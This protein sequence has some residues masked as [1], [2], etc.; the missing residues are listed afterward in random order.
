LSEF[1]PDYY[2]DEYYRKRNYSDLDPY[3]KFLLLD[4]LNIGLNKRIR[5]LDIG[6]GTGIYLNFLKEMGFVAYGIDF[7]IPALKISKQIQASATKIPFKNDTFDFILSAHLIEHLES[8]KMQEMLNESQRVLKPGGK[9]FL[10]T[11]NGWCLG[12]FVL[13]KDWFKDPSHINIYNPKKIKNVLKKNQ[14][15]DIKL[16]HRIPFNLQKEEQ[17]KFIISY[18]GLD[19]L[20]NKFPILQDLMFFFITSTLL[21][22]FR[23]VIYVTAEVKK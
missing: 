15:Q 13:G 9:I 7:S 16:T 11:P 8:N 10:L 12:K 2:D 22:Y 4:A 20:F 6:C 3:L 23:D 5:I 19:K 1:K 21:A 14:F 17:N 18:Y